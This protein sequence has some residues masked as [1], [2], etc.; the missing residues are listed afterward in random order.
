MQNQSQEE[1]QEGREWLSR[2]QAIRSG[3]GGAFIDIEGWDYII[4]HFMQKED[5]RNAR[6]ACETAL[7]FF[8]DSP[9]LLMNYAHILLAFGD[10]EKSL[11]I[12]SKIEPLMP[13]SGAL[14]VMKCTILN[15][16]NRHEESL[17]YLKECL[18]A[19]DPDES[20]RVLYIVGS[21]LTDMGLTNEAIS[22][23]RRSLELNPVSHECLEEL[24]FC[25]EEEGN[26][27]L[28]LPDYR[29]ALDK[30]PFDADLWM[31]FAALLNILEEFDE[32]LDAVDYCLALDEKRHIAWF[33]RANILM[34]LK[35]FAEAETDY[36]KA[37]ELFDRQAEYFV[38]IG[39]ALECQEKHDQAIHWFRK[40]VK[41][42]PK[43]SDGL[44]GIGSCLL[45]MDKYAESLHFFSKAIQLDEFNPEYWLG[46][47]MAENQLGNIV[48]AEEA[49]AKVY[50]LDP[51]NVNLWLDWSFLYYDQGEAAR[52]VSM[53]DEAIALMPEESLLYYR[54]AAY[55]FGSGQAKEAMLYLENGILLNYDH[56]AVLYDF[57]D[58]IKTQKVLYNLVQD[59][60]NKGTQL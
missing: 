11:G 23:F 48:S 17:A 35:R 34:N 38:G 27:E 15:H 14:I 58:D 28:V 29:A 2:Y 55:L 7:Q 47:A 1:E 3:K 46:K 10:M 59:I 4:F 32:A 31:S 60:K 24:A 8:P 51:E 13:N 53:L 20:D 42:D 43:Q 41:I 49:F 54:A 5:H 21:T 30:S 26:P 45:G 52:A 25:Y 33:Q 16:E 56:H 40:A 9:D 37:I 12:I 22:W 50:E 18:A 36:G 6:E 19:G 44:Y 57:F 39:A